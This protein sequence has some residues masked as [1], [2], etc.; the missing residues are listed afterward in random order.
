M[1]IERIDN[2]LCTGCGICVKSCPSDVLRLDPATKKAV[3]RYPEDC[4]L[5]E[6][7]RKDCPEH[8]VVISPDKGS[9][10]LTSWG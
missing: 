10:V 2:S 9:P 1:A 3:V 8:A 4:V 5:C 6:W 7:C